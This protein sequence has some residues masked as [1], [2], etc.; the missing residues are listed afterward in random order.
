MSA[1]IRALRLERGWSQAELARRAGL[2]RPEVSAVETGRVVPSV[3][4]ALGFGRAFGVAVEA[5]FSAERSPLSWAVPPAPG[6]TRAWIADVGDRRLAYPC[7]PGPLGLR[8]HDVVMGADGV[9]PDTEPP[10]TLVMAGC[11]PAVALL[12]DALSRRGIRVLALARSSGDALELLKQGLVHV[13]GVHLG[14]AGPRSNARAVKQR[15]GVGHAILRWANWQEGLVTAPGVKA[16]ADSVGRL[17]RLSWVGR[18]PGSGARACIE[19]VFAGRR[20]PRFS[21]MA[22]DHHGVTEAIRLGA[23][24]AGVCVRLAAEDAGLSFVPLRDEAYDLCFRAD[25]DP[26]LI[27][28]LTSAVR[29]AGV[30]RL[31][32]ELPGYDAAATG[33]LLAV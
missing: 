32:S 19:E 15:L 25:V 7:E 33:E 26:E 12:A 2:S 4:A 13:A 10:P 3:H 17:A 11:D 18:E 22:R 24:E 27:R 21:A 1:R 30:R 9:L 23:A 5:L 16:D 14:R 6:T 29:D 8:P 20:V 28:A 31:L